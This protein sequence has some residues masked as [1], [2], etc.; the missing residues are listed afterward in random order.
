[1]NE[2]LKY[3]QGA[4]TIPEENKI[5][6]ATYFEGPLPHPDILEKQDKYMDLLLQYQQLLELLFVPVL[7]IHT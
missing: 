5:A 7:I 2:R 4:V 3:S 6:K 1:M